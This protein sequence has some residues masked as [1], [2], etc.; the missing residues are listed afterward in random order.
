MLRTL[1]RIERTLY[2]ERQEAAPLLREREAFLEHLLQQGTSLAAARGVSWQLLNVIRLLRLTRLR[3]VG[4][5]EIERAAHRWA[6][7]QRSDSGVQSCRHSASYFI[8]VAKKWLRFAGVLKEATVRRPRF[9]DALDEFARWM[10]EEK[11]AAVLTVRSHESKTAQFLKWFSERRRSL[12]AVRLRD[13][14]DFLVFKGTSGWSRKSARGYADALRAFFR[15]AAQRKWC[16]P[17][18]AEGILSPKLYVHE[19][20]PEGPQWK[21]VQRLLE[22]VKG[23]SVVGL[24]ARAVLLLLTVYGLRSG[25][26][27]RLL[28]SDFDWTQETFTVNHSKRGGAQKYPLQREVGDAI[29]EYIRKARPR[30]SCRNLFLTLHPPYRRIGYTS[31]WRITSTRIDAAGI[32]CRRRGPHS[33]RHACA[34]HLLEQGASLKEIGDLLGHRDFNSTRIYAKVHLQ[35]LRRVAD[36]DLGGLL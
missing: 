27:S 34:T 30:T 15:Y 23:D 25:E 19:G 17:G 32:Q 28:L 2:A 5:D 18:I 8:Y 21:D 22:D 36:F 16:K 6:R 11:G 12:A 7:R 10:T 1:L 20:L 24:R 3:N 14:D 4:I 33:L 31:I 26:I 29:L 35:Q 9:A 13:V